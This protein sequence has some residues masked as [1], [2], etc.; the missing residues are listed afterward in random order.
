MESENLF[1]SYQLM[2]FFGVLLVIFLAYVGTKFIS[3]K[4]AKMSSGKNIKV[5]ERI[6]LGQDKSLVL[7]SLNKKAYLLGVTGKDISIVCQLDEN[8]LATVSVDNQADFLSLLTDGIKKSTT[9]LK[10]PT[11]IRKFSEGFKNQSFLDTSSIKSFIKN[12][13]KNGK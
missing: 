4:Y 12:K 5:L 6:A 10:L 3:A 2:P 8:E 9:G 7:I 1:D 13:N 11:D